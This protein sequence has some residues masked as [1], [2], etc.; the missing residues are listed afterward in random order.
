[1]TKVRVVTWQNVFAFERAIAY[2][3]SMSLAEIKTAVKELSPAELAELATFV[4]EQDS[5][6]WDNEMERDFSPGGK[7]YASL[8]KIDA[9]IDAGHSKPL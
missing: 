6:A 9:A 5:L 4:R 7:H 2:V 3:T 1:M 8:A